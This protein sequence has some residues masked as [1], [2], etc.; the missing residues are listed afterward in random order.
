MFVLEIKRL[1]EFEIKVILGEKDMRIMDISFKD[2]ED[3]APRSEEFLSDLMFIMR[4]TG[5]IKISEGSVDVDVA[6]TAAGTI[7]IYFR[8]PKSD[9][10]RSSTELAVIAAA[11]DELAKKAAEIHKEYSDK[12]SKACLY[13]F[14]GGYALIF[15]VNYARSTVAKKQFLKA[16]TADGIVINKIKEH[17]QLMT[18]APFEKLNFLS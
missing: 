16:C 8:L 13:G 11:P 15:T 10:R 9:Q 1:S 17:S 3:N 2:F 4:E 18:D 5:L 6:L 7:N 12:I 14:S